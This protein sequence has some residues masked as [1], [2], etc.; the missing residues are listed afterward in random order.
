MARRAGVFLK[1]SVI[2]FGFLNGVWVAVGVNP[3]RQLLDVLA[4]VVLRLRPGRG[5]EALV[6]LLP[7]LVLALT[8]WLIHRAWRKGRWLGM[9]AVACGFLAG[10]Q[11]LSDP[12]AALALLGAAALLGY[13]ATSR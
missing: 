9:A 3:G 12:L 4:G 10:M 7:F 11:V 5:V 13:A 6:A 2:L 8:L 1:E